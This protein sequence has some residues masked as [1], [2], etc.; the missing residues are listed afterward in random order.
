MVVRFT[1][2]N[3]LLARQPDLYLVHCQAYER[4][5]VADSADTV[6]VLLLDGY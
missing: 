6:Y 3:E 4:G 2:R 5:K 1:L